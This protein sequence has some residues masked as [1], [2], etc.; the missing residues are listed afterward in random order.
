MLATSGLQ[1]SQCQYL[2]SCC[3][4]IKGASLGLPK[5]SVVECIRSD[6]SPTEK[7]LVGTDRLVHLVGSP[8]LPT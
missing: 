3:L 7:A 2:P 4:A 6:Q 8:D 1:T 5:P